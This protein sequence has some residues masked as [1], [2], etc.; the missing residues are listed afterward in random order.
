[1]SLG[2]TFSSAAFFTFILSFPIAL[3]ITRSSKITSNWLTIVRVALVWEC[4]LYLFQQENLS[5]H[6]R[7]DVRLYQN[8]YCSQSWG[9]DSDAVFLPSPRPTDSILLVDVSLGRCTRCFVHWPPLWS[10]WEFQELISPHFPMNYWL[11]WFQHYHP[12]SLCR[13]SLC[14]TFWS[15]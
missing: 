5:G 12:H 13:L 6:C 4:R 9:K 2:T 1:M 14:F 10:R 15:F 8:W 11:C 7:A 3:P